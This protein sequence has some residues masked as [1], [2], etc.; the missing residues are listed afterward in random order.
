MF[1]W[2]KILYALR[3]APRSFQTT[4]YTAS[5]PCFFHY[6][7]H[8]HRFHLP[9]TP[10]QLKHITNTQHNASSSHRYH[11]RQQLYQASR[12][13]PRRQGYDSP[14]S[15]KKGLP[16]LMNQVL[17][18]SQPQSIPGPCLNETLL[19][20]LGSRS[21]ETARNQN[22]RILQMVCRPDSPADVAC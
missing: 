21:L 11:A 12:G 17:P 13:S 10:P 7:P 14:F 6:S 18:D 22:F 15:S 2:G 8:P 16:E 1:H 4:T 3:A 20:E 19:P 5:R 9:F